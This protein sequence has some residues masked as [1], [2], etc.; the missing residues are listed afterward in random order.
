MNAKLKIVRRKFK[1]HA[2]IVNSCHPARRGPEL[3]CSGSDD[4]QIIVHDLR[5][6]EAV[7]KM[8]N[9]NQ[10]QV[11]AVTFNDTSEKVIS[12]G[13]DNVLKIWDLRRG[14]E[15]T[16]LVGH[17]DTVT[18]LALSP[19]GT[20]VLSNSMDCT[21]RIWD[22]RPYAPEQRCLKVFTG[23]QHNFEKNL[24]KCAWSPDS[25]KITCGSSDRFVY[26]WEVGSRRIAY[27]L[28]GHQGSVNAVD[29]HP[30]EPIL[31]SAGSDKRIYLGELDH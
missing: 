4:G 22:V 29:F 6:K 25:H 13:I 21:A 9:T 28:P 12:G 26:V 7:F 18:A 17:T 19:E 14:E 30:T 10:F 2:D 16:V 1:S 5:E 3:I 23:H 31:L 20:Y 24:M 8:T 15:P 27:K 11:T